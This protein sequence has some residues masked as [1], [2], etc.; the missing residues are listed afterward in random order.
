MRAEET[1]CHRD[2]IV[3]MTDVQLK[4]ITNV[5]RSY[6]ALQHLLLFINEED[7]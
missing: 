5:P 1:G 7:G 2:I 6:D 4:R 3:R